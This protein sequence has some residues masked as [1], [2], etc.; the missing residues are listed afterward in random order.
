MVYGFYE[1]TGEEIVDRDWLAEYYPD[2]EIFATSVIRNY[3]ECPCY[4]VICGFDELGQLFL[5]EE[6]K[7]MVDNCYDAIKQIT[8]KSAVGFHLVLRGDYHFFQQV[9]SPEYS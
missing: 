7:R 9:Y 4:G 6:K 3:A 5:E 2:I 1:I 8:L